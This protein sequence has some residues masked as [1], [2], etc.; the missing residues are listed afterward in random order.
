MPNPKATI[1]RAEAKRAAPRKPSRSYGPALWD[2]ALDPAEA[3]DVWL[4][5]G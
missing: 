2:A 3:F 1:A 4:G 5:E